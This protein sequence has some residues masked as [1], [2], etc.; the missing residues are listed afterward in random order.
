MF[1]GIARGEY[2]MVKLSTSPS[3]GFL[4]RAWRN[5][6]FR[7]ASYEIWENVLEFQL[8]NKQDRQLTYNVT[9]RRVRLAIVAMDKYLLHKLVL[10]TN[11]MHNSFIL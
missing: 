5:F 11:L 10:I 8:T 1:A 7:E 9:H 3:S 6:L 4:T 2:V